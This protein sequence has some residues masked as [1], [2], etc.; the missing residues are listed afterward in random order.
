MVGCRVNGIRTVLPQDAPGGD[1]GGR[2]W[3]TSG[4]GASKYSYVLL[5]HRKYSKLTFVGEKSLGAKC[6]FG[7]VRIKQTKTKNNV[8]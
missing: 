5:Q 2:D 7:S 1:G 8:A 6:R 4:L 3:A